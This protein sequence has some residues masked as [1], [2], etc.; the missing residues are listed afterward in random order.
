MGIKVIR[1]LSGSMKHQVHVRQ[2][3][4]MADVDEAG[5]GED[6]GPSP[7]D[8][9]DASLGA[10]KAL[11]VLWYAKRKGIPVEVVE[12][13]IERDSTLEQKGTYRL[14]ALLKLSGS[15][16]EAQRTELLNVA[17]K[18]PVHKLMTTVTTE[19]ETVLA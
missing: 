3:T 7:H 12:V 1:D 5:G 13:E 11:T 17:S 8:L 15:L 19:I 10:C 9:Y 14:K 16:S 18:C 2:H 6:A 4:F